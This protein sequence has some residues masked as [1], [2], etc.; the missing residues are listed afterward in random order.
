MNHKPTNIVAARD[1]KLQTVTSGRSSTITIIAGGNALGTN[2]PPF[3]V[4]RGQRMRDELLVDGTP[5]T[6]S[7]V[8]DSGWSNRDFHEIHERTLNSPL[9]VMLK[10]QS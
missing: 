5:G 3:C 1:L 9:L 10:S 6:D 2:I 8:S 7:T 4:F